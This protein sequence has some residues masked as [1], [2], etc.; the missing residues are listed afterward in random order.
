MEFDGCDEVQPLFVLFLFF[1]LFLFTFFKLK[2]TDGW[3]RRPVFTKSNEDGDVSEETEKYIEVAATHANKSKE[4]L[5][6][7]HTTTHTK[8]QK[9]IYNLTST[10]SPTSSQDG[11]AYRSPS[12]TVL[13]T[14]LNFLQ[15]TII[16]PV[17]TRASMSLACYSLND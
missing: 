6:A 11:V 5:V 12:S 2:G 8:H 4:T 13:L 15:L 16:S 10:V 7:K 1:I 3:K 14:V 9:H 17:W